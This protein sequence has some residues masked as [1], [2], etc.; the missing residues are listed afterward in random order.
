MMKAVF[1]LLVPRNFT[2]IFGEVLEGDPAAH[3]VLDGDS[4]HDGVAS[5]IGALC[6]Y[7]QGSRN[8]GG[9]VVVSGTL[10]P[11]VVLGWS[12]IP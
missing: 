6:T 9:E 4:S 7:R 5:L 3:T 8:G 12:T 2:A 1:G 10:I 11:S